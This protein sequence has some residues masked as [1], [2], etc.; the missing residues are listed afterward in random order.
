[1]AVQGRQLLIDCGEG[2]QMQ[3][4]KHGLSLNAIDRIFISHLHG[5]HYLGLMGLLFSM[6]LL[7]REA[8]LHIH[9]FRGLDEI[10]I[11]QLRHAQ[12]ALHFPVHFHELTH[13]L[14]V[15]WE[16]EAITVTSLPL[17]HKIPCVGFL[18]REKRKPFRID[19]SKI[20]PAVRLQDLA[21]FK[22]GKD[23]Y[24]EAGKLAAR[25]EDFTLPPRPSRAY[26]YCSDT[27]FDPSLA[28]HLRGVDLLYHEA[29]FLAED[30]DKALATGH[31]TAAEAAMLARDAGVAQ[32]LIGHFSARYQDAAPLLQEA[33]AIFEKTTPAAEGLCIELT[34]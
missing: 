5:D 28:Q 2:A 16:D 32:L 8:P 14:Q 18:I 30:A 11:C 25:H 21:L 10:I 33:Q 1:V 15:V 3:L 34:D 19:K 22:Q 4:M 26:A 27:R 6:H 31:T 23:V 24:D 9:A 29:T 13:T 7:K 20:T 17:Q 12:S